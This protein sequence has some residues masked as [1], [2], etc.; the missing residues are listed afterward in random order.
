MSSENFT[1]GTLEAF[2]ITNNISY[3]KLPNEALTF[4]PEPRINSV[5]LINSG[6]L[7]N[8]IGD[9]T[10]VINNINILIGGVS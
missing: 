7:Y 9:I 2:K 1:G 6:D 10:T 3:V 4:D 5:N 8:I